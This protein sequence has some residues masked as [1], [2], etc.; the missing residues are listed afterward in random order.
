M[1]VGDNLQMWQKERISRY[2]CSL[3]AN[4]IDCIGGVAALEAPQKLK[5]YRT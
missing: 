2:L 5:Q 1:E 4:N 3:A